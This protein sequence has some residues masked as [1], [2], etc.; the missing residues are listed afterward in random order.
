MSQSTNQYM[1]P[2]QHGV[3]D[4]LNISTV[5]HVFYRTGQ[6]DRAVYWTD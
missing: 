4:V 5:V 3:H 2:V 1:E 6:T